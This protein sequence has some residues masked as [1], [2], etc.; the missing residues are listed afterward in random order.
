[1]E[2]Y[3]GGYLSRNSP[4][5][6]FSFWVIEQYNSDLFNRGWLANV[7]IKMVSQLYPNIQC[8]IF[9][10]VDL[11]PKNGTFVPYNDCDRPTQLGSELQHWGWGVPYKNSAG[12][13]VSMHVRH[14]YQINGFS[15]DFEGWGGED[16]DLFQ[17]LRMN[18]LLDNSTKTIRRPS[19]GHGI[20]TTISED[21]HHH[22]E[23][24]KAGKEYK[25]SLQILTSMEQGSN[26]W[27][28]DGL[29]DLT[30]KILGFENSSSLQ[31]FVNS[32]HLRVVP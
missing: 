21:R 7:G 30:Y 31:M 22:P 12:G 1:M 16:D 19:K 27:K 15:N 28:S 20:F 10:D 25:N 29:S 5:E 6:T 26:R 23:K 11:I 3:L 2:K 18:G 32:H 4:N 8:I 9:H 14:W 13:I 17:R 24:V